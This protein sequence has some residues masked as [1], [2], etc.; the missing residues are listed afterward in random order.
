[1]MLQEKY[2]LVDELL[3]ILGKLIA[4]YISLKVS[5]D[6]KQRVLTAGNLA[7]LQIIAQQEEKIAAVIATLEERRKTLQ[8]MID[9]THTSF[10]QLIA[11]LE[12]PRKQR[13]IALSQKLRQLVKDMS[14]MQES[15]SIVLHN[16]L[17]LENHKRNILFKVSTVPEYG[18]NNNFANKT[19]I[20][21][22]FR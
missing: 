21:N 3:D 14:V 20:I 4:I 13:G 17:K 15:N 6:D 11:L 9:N 10:N 12:E 5:N 19:S 16:L 7:D 18:G 22:L 8:R 2:D 1:M